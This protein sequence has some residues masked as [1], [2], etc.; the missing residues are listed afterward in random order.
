MEQNLVKGIA[1]RLRRRDSEAIESLVSVLHGPVYRYLIG[2]GSNVPQAEE[3][4]AETFFQVLRS[5]EGFRGDDNQVRAFVFSTVRNVRSRCHRQTSE[6]EFANDVARNVI[7]AEELP[8]QRLLAKE[9]DKQVADAVGQLSDVAR[10]IVFL[11]FV[12]DTS[13]NEI[14]AICDLPAGT[15][16]SHLHR[17]KQEL[18]RTIAELEYPQ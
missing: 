3:L 14:A 11:R 18:K 8:L 1:E 6:L 7:D 10:E 12:E 13:I 17:A 9:R 5:I 4:T 16:K 15:V 2:C